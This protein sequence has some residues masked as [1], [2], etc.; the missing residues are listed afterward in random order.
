MSI[1]KV[2]VSG[3]LTRE[4]ELRMAGAT[5]VLQF[6]IAVNDR[7]KNNQTGEWEDVPNFFDVVVWGARGESLARFLSKG[8]KVVI[9]GRLRWSQWQNS[10]GQNRSKVE[11]VAEDVEFMSSRSADQPSGSAPYAAP[12]PAHV[13]VEVLGEDIPF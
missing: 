13:P 7:R 3:N 12:Q 8:S 1:N 4:P 2:L 11:I 6:G 10:E 9:S 5:P